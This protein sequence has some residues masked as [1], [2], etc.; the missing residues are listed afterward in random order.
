MYISG[1]MDSTT[2]DMV[3]VLP[4]IN[5]ESLKTNYEDGIPPSLFKLLLTVNIGSV[6]VTRKF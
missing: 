2:V 6:S 5:E 1:L 3:T 4:A